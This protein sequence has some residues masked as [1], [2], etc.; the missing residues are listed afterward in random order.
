MASVDDANIKFWNELCGTNLATVLG[1]TDSSPGSLKK[2]D[3]WFFEFYPYLLEH[4]SLAELI[5]RDVLEVGLG[6]GSLSQKIAESGAR[7]VGLDIAPGPVEM[8]CHRLRQAAL[9]GDAKTGSILNAPFSDNS[10]DYVVAVGC[11]HHTGDMRKG[12]DECRRLLRAGGSLIAM[13]YY[14][15]SY[16]RWVQAPRQTLRYLTSEI[17]G[18][19][20]VVASET[21]QE[22]WY[23]DH[24]SKGVVAP[25]TDFVSVKSLRNYCR[26]FSDFS[27]QRRNI[28]QELPFKKRTRQELLA[29]RWPGICGLEIYARAVK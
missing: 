8:V 9:P 19:R 29:T 25:H 24:N 15:Y 3:D 23:Y 5:G 11:L 22:K 16:R 21:A 20:G 12:I 7:Y 28:D 14:A 1:I 27:W 2:F 26:L 10:F 4:V 18:Y 17:L 6:Y 13:V